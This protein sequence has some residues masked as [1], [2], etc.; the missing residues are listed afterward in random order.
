MEFIVERKHIF[1]DNRGNPLNKVPGDRVHVDNRFVAK[2]LLAQ[3]IIRHINMPRSAKALEHPA[4][5]HSN[6]GKT[7]ILC[8]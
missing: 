3:G 2:E 6:P 5:P 1:R 4:R 8:L 7:Y